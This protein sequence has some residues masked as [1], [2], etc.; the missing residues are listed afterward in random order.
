[1]KD[2]SKSLFEK[3][4]SMQF[5]YIKFEVS[6]NNKEFFYDD[7]PIKINSVMS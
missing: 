2:I 7:V 4:Y 5:N 6:S 1:M 3:I